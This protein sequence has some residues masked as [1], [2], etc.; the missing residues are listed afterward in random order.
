VATLLA[1][2]AEGLHEVAQGGGRVHLEGRD[3]TAV[4]GLGWA[5]LDGTEVVHCEHGRWATYGVLPDGTA[6]TCLAVAAHEV[7]LGTEGAG[8]LRRDDEGFAEVPAFRQAPG[9][10]SWYTPW[11]GPPDTRSL[12]VADDGTVLVNV[13]VGGILRSDDGGGTWAPTIDL[14]VDVHQVVAVPGTS[15]VLAATGTGLA[16]SGD[17]GRTWAVDDDGLHASYLRAVAVAGDVVL[18]SASRGPGGA[19]PALYRRPLA[20][21]PFER[22]GDGLPGLGG[23]VDTGWLVAGEEL[24]AVVLADGSIHRSSDAGSRFECVADG[25]PAPRGLACSAA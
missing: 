10:H 1:A 16:T 21:G 20:G 8:L 19:D 24:V 2:T 25:L 15:T 6:A 22:I 14:D 3:V 7:Y 5:V 13:H 12:A 4:H 23:N 11:G 9:R 17:G 18:V